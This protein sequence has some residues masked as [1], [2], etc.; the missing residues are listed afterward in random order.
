MFLE[1]VTTWKSN[2]SD[3]IKREF[4]HAVAVLILLYYNETFEEKD[5]LEK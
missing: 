3:K 4:S 5:R 2:L 1:L